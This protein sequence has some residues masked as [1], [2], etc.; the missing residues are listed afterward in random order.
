MSRPLA[1]HV[2]ALND[3]EFALYTAAILDISEHDPADV[4]D[5]DKLDVGVREA[6]AWLRGR[7][8][9][10]TPAALAG[11]CMI[12]VAFAVLSWSTWREMKEDAARHEEAAAAAG[13]PVDWSSEDESD[14]DDDR[15]S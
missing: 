7:Y 11:G 12:V 3:A 5:Y 14:K 15:L 10:L 9:A 2:S 13:G 4:Q 8:P 6:R 1:L